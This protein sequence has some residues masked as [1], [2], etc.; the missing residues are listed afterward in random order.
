MKKCRKCQRKL[1]ID[2]FSSREGNKD[3]LHIYCKNCVR[4]NR[5]KYDQKIGYDNRKKKYH[6]DPQFR[7]KMIKWSTKPPGSRNE[8]LKKYYQLNKEKMQKN[9][10]E[11][12]ENNRERVNKWL[13]TYYKDPSK[14]VARNMYNRVRI[15]LFTQLTKKKVGTQE[16]CGCTWNELVRYLEARFKKGMTWQNYGKGHGKWSIDHI[17]PCDSFDLTVPEEMHKCFHY[18]N[19][20][21]LWTSENSSK[22]NNYSDS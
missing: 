20:Q 16:L 18:S 21:P 5:Q 4:N 7:K 1:N 19:M 12:R 11:Y 6:S 17:V 13:Q 9:S 10:K 22:R 2:Q 15:A 14:R 3:G 8:Y